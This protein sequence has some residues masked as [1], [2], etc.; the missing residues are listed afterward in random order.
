MFDSVYDD[1]RE[2]SREVRISVALRGVS[3]VLRFVSSYARDEIF[4][5]SMGPGV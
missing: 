2:I 5:E 1:Q 4:I 3:C